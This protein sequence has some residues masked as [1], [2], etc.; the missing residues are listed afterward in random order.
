MI[1]SVEELCRRCG[2]AIDGDTRRQ[3]EE[4]AS[5]YRMAVPDYYFGLIDWEDPDCPIRRQCIPDPRELQDEVYTEDPLRE[6][7]FSGVPYLVHKYRDRAAFMASNACYMYCRHCT[8]K[9]T[10]INSRRPTEEEFENVL[11]YLRAHKEIKDVLVTGGDP[12]TLPVELL[13]HYLTEIRNIPSV[14]TIRI[15]TRAIVVNPEAVTEEL[16]DMLKK[17]HPLWVFT[18]FNHPK[19]ITPQSEAACARLLDRGIPLGNQSVLLRGINDQEQVMEDLLR[20]LIR[21]R[22]RPYYVYLC[23]KVKGTRHFATD[24]GTGVR[25][26]E[27]M[28]YRVPG[29]AVPKFVIDADGENGGKVTIEASHILEETEDYLILSG[30]CEGEVTKYYKGR[31][32]E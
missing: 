32:S 22:V 6:G 26:M 8:R 12:F 1:G 15:G 31:C 14:E 3:M 17:H 16:A 27:K 28:R 29:Y 13:D 7:R 24:Y 2:D 11:G 5:K 23:D 20:G 30:L 9:N 18:Q 21:I 10:V 25:L 4:T 19:E